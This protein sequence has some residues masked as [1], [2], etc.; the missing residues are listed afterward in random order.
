MTKNHSKTCL[1]C[2][3]KFV[4]KNIRGAYCSARCRVSANRKKS[5]TVTEKVHYELS[6]AEIEL[7]KAKKLLHEEEQKLISTRILSDR[8]NKA[9]IEKQVNDKLNLAELQKL[10]NQRLEIQNQ[11]KAKKENSIITHAIKLGETK[12]EKVLALISG[13]IIE[14]TFSNSEAKRNEDWE[15]K[16]IDSKIT[17]INTML[18]RVVLNPLIFTNMKDIELEVEMLKLRCKELEDEIARSKSIKEL[19]QIKDKDGFVMAKDV[20]NINFADRIQLSGALG[21]FIGLLEKDKCAITLTGKPGSG[22]TYLCFDL[23]SK[24]IE[25]DF[26]VAYFSIE[27]G[28]TSLTQQ[29]I[30]KY[31]LQKAEKFKINDQAT[32][33]DIQN[34]AEGFDVIVIDSWGKLN[35]DIAE[36]DKL[37]MAFPKTIFISIFQLTSSGQMRGGTMAA[38]DAGINIE[39]SI[40]DNKRFAICSKNRYGN[41]GVK[42]WIDERVLAF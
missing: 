21:D 18:K 8:Y 34:F 36:F 7:E 33:K 32:L 11:Q 37:R 2:N 24:F 42:Y 40:I 16:K 31:K 19:A 22:K 17:K 14:R 27:E 12:Q 28:I 39:T 13:V 35:A 5:V 23:I 29:K 15:L 41:T 20:Q 9:L 1:N 25:Q 4:A 26:S 10:H 38:F 30:E 3:K 6:Q